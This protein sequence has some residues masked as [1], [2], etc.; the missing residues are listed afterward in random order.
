MVC[1]S[2]YTPL[3]SMR[4]RR[5]DPT[6]H[7]HPRTITTLS[8]RLRVC[9][10]LPS[11]EIAR[12]SCP[13]IPSTA[14]PGPKII[15]RG[16]D[17]FGERDSMLSRASRLNKSRTGQ[18]EHNRV[19]FVF[20][21]ATALTPSHLRQACAWGIIGSPLATPL[22]F[23]RLPPST[24]AAVH[25]ICSVGGTQCRWMRREGQLLGEEPRLR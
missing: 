4:A 18:V 10:A 11:P 2:C 21:R 17:S 9:R 24:R 5:L 8:Q 16:G 6:L 14:G 3:L 13:M 22:P 20:L 25:N 12:Q 19:A 15:V 1:C 7:T 23:H